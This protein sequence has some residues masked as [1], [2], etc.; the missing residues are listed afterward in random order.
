MKKLFLLLLIIFSPQVFADAIDTLRGSFNKLK[1]GEV[2]DA[3]SIVKDDLLGASEYLIGLNYYTGDVLV[4]KDISKAVKWF[5][6][7]AYKGHKEAKRRLAYI[8]YFAEGSIEKDTVKAESYLRYAADGN[9]VKDSYWQFLLGLIYES[10][11]KF[12]FAAREYKRGC[13]N[14]ESRACK[15]YDKV[16][17]KAVLKGVS[18]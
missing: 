11:K 13:S 7:A 15:Y 6:E 2:L 8:Y 3:L 5:D 12:E 10:N 14:G 18:N 16:K 4:D 1:E 9:S 17:V